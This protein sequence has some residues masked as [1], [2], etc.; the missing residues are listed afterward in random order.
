VESW[1]I[2]HDRAMDDAAS[3]PPVS[4]TPR[5]AVRL[6]GH[7][8]FRGLP[9]TVLEF[10]Q[11]AFS[12]LRDNTLRGVLAEFLVATAVGDNRGP[13]IGWD[14]FDVQTPSGV[15]VEVKCSAFLQSWPQ[16]GP[17]RL[18]FGRLRARWWDP[19]TGTE[20]VDDPIRAQVFVFAIQTQQDHELYDMLDVD[21]WEFWTAS[22]AAVRAHAGKS[23]GIGWVRQRA[24][25]PYAYHQLAAAIE[26]TA[27]R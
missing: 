9:A 5:P 15:T 24:S 21:H 23:V 1:A 10:W 20:V 22:G 4:R 12:D 11:W 17:S 16:R 27:R 6:T 2:G 13:R 18:S 26:D 7:E 19:D 14:N 3:V 8:Q 25:G